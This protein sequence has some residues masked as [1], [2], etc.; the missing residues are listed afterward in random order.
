[1]TEPHNSQSRE[2]SR[3]W[4]RVL[5]ASR[6]ASSWRGGRD[7]ALAWLAARR[8]HAAFLHLASRDGQ[9]RPSGRRAE[10]DAS[11]WAGWRRAG[12]ESHAER[13]TSLSA[14]HALQISANA[15][16]SL[17]EMLAARV[18]GQREQAPFTDALRLL[19][20][21]RAALMY[22]LYVNRDRAASEK[23]LRH[24]EASGVNAVMLTVDAPVMG[25][26]ERDMRC[27]GEVVS[28]G[29]GTATDSEAKGVAQAISQYID[30]DLV[31]RA[32]SSVP[33][34]ADAPAT[35]RGTSSTGTD[36]SA[37]CH[38][39]SRASRRWR[40]PYWPR[41][42]ACR[43]SSSRTT[44]AA[45]SSTAHRRSTCSLSCARGGQTCSTRCTCTS[46]AA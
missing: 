8:A 17:D 34:L 32:L 24:V 31:R 35:S 33:R 40:M 4:A 38:C 14:H 12:S 26:R 10:P 44:A 36:P 43:A 41:S 16:V 9:A 5:P 27:K 37:S 3:L 11:R 42:T 6:S 13:I 30:P 7:S 28:V 2:P 22:Q 39:S 21:S 20:V 15:S 45:A 23:I 29:G 19:I 46:M 1:M 18:E 25:K